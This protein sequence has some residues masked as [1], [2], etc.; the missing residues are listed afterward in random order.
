VESGWTSRLSARASGLPQALL[1]WRGSFAADS[2]PRSRF[3]AGIAV[4]RLQALIPPGWEMEER[5]AKDAAAVRSNPSGMGDGSRRQIHAWIAFPKPE[6]LQL[7][8]GGQAR[9]ERHHRI[10]DEIWTA[11][12]RRA[13]HHRRCPRP[14]PPSIKRKIPGPLLGIRLTWRGAQDFDH[15]KASNSQFRPSGSARAGVTQRSNQAPLTDSS[16][17]PSPRQPIFSTPFP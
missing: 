17:G 16:N 1:C 14:A 2:S 5:P 6:A 11:R 12:R 4:H 15:I 10:H 13:S 7:V 3:A 9:N 8:A